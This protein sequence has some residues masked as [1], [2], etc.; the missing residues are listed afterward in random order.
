MGDDSRHAAHSSFADKVVVINGGTQGLGEAS[1]RLMTRRGAAGVV[2]TGRS[3]ER[4]EALASELTRL[5]TEALFLAV[6]LEDADSVAEVIPM[7]DERFGRADVLVN[8]GALTDR[9]TISSTTVDAWDRFQAVNV[10]AP[11][12]LTQGAVALM[13]REAIAGSIVNIG[14]VVSYGGVPSLLPYAVSKAALTAFTKNVAY[15]V[16]RDRIRVNIIN[17]G[18]MNTAS[19]DIVQRKW[20]GAGDDWLEL[21]SQQM[22]FGRIIETDE[23]ARAICYLASD[24]SGLMTGATLD[25]DQ[26][27]VGAGVPTV[28]PEG[29]FG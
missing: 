22:P 21:A 7:V 13:R 15:S 29:E 3:V 23:A 1:A 12:Q 10:R 16:M 18:W 8:A 6:E 14:S 25:F 9:G 4:G 24:E 5:G 27:V 28:P 26:S 17:L 19:E 2:I 20:E 11:F